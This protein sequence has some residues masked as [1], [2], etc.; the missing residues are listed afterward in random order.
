MQREHRRLCLSERLLLYSFLQQRN[1]YHSFIAIR[2]QIIL[3]FFKQL[4]RLIGLRECFSQPIDFIGLQMYVLHVREKRSSFTLLAAPGLQLLLIC[5]RHF[6]LRRR[7]CCILHFSFDMRF[8]TSYK[9]MHY[10]WLLNLD[11]SSAWL[12]NRTKN[13]GGWYEEEKKKSGMTATLKNILIL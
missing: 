7:C 11:V 10:Q 13:G 12:R 8:V 9:Q 6:V 3:A 4:I 1:L 5:I 2:F